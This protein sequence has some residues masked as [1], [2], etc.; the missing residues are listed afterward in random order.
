MTLPRPANFYGMSKVNQLQNSNPIH[1]SQLMLTYIDKLILVFRFTHSFIHLLIHP[2]VHLLVHPSIHPSLQ[3]SA[4]QSIYEWRP[5]IECWHGSFVIFQGVRTSIA[6]KPYI[7]CDF[8]GG[9][10]GP[11][12]L[13]PLDQRKTRPVHL[14]IIPLYTV[15][16]DHRK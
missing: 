4:H 15:Q 13:P 9:G 1:Q 5:N 8:S 14:V 16:F 12:P 6:K 11:P 3:P 7:F 10:S 2:S